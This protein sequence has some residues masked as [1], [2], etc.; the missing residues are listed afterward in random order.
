MKQKNNHS[1]A[2]P[3]QHERLVLKEDNP[4]VRNL[5]CGNEVEYNDE[6]RWENE[7]T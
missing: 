1:Y 4:A 2:M 7:N 3:Q 5:E 6:I